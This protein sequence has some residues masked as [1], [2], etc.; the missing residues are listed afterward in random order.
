MSNQNRKNNKL[1]NEKSPY[2][3]QHAYNPVDWYPWSIEAF[4]KAKREN[5]PIFLSIGYSTC[6]WC[7]VMAHESFED[8]EVAELL[9]KSFVCIKVDREERP[10]IDKVYMNVCHMI[11]GSGGW[12]L[13]IIM[14]PD[15][16]PFFAATY[17]PKET[18]YGIKGLL[19]IL[20]EIKDLWDNKTN[21]LLI[22]AREITSKLQKVTKFKDGQELTQELL[23][24]TFEQL[25]N[26][27]DE[28]Y[29]GF[30]YQPK[31]PTPHNLLF[32]LRY[33]K[34]TG[35]NYS[36]K[37]VETTLEQ[38]RQGGIYDHIGFGFHR[39]STDR[40]WILP[41]FEKM[42]Y[43]QALILVAYI[44]TYQATKKSIFKKTANEIIEY[45]IRDMTSEKG[46]FYSAEDADSEGVEGKF[47]TWHYD[48][49]KQILTSEELDLV[50]KFY[51]IKKEGNFSS[52]AE[53]TEK[54]NIFYQTMS[55]EEF[56]EFYQIKEKDFLEKLE[57]IREKLFQIRKIRIHPEKDDKILTDWNGLMIAALS[58]A[59]Q[60]FNNK[61]YLEKA[62]KASDFIIHNMISKNKEL[63]HSYRKG[64]AKISGYADDYTFLI[65]GFIELYQATF[66]PKYLKLSFD[67]NEYLLNYFWDKSNG[68]LF[69]TSDVNE[70]ILTN[71]KEVYDGAIPSANSIAMYN[72]IRLARITGNKD[73]E[74]K[75][76][77][78]GKT[79]SNQIIKMPSSHTQTM[80]GLDFA[81]GPSYEIVVVGDKNNKNTE[82]IIKNIN[83]IYLPNKVLI[84]K[85]P[86]S[87]DLLIEN[88]IPFIKNYSQINN[89]PTIYVCKN[90]QCQQPIKDIEK[91]KQFFE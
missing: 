62:E 24:T 61:I 53:K 55:N 25:F 13:T 21:D 42:L 32:L 4:N 75:A 64:E 8:I 59:S 16:K 28:L 90:L 5:K 63:L 7:H 57:I 80:I 77:Q 58:K 9:N 20:P 47:Y 37:M 1:I 86:V 19:T 44:E 83:S 54:L 17:I 23:N 49:L 88:L 14:T 31:F 66:N 79:F 60:V 45:I 50:I 26:S 51:N 27:F 67:L 84:L 12:P 76:N 87:K 56:I 33:W 6:H 18:R 69:F 30:G 71:T 85:E 29:G 40:K 89:K 15:K 78:I 36:L 70:K 34:R 41:H 22:S 72:L 68:G 81:V 52:G 65:F 35:N 11:K 82:E 38:M 39:Y 3:L 74:E 73:F 10:D 46:G 43:D 48:E 91:M 2:L